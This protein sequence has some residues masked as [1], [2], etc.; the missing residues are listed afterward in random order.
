MPFTEGVLPDSTRIALQ[1]L[2]T[3]LTYS[4]FTGVDSRAI[5]GIYPTRRKK[6]S[7]QGENIRR[8]TTGIFLAF[9]ASQYLLATGQA[10]SACGEAVRLGGRGGWFAAVKFP[11]R[12]I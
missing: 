1:F 6:L 7:L 8:T 11:N 9:P 3:V 4:L 12:G 10:V 2:E 5:H